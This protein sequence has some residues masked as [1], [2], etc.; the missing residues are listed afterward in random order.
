MR[1]K[2]INVVEQVIE[3][4]KIQRELGEA[5]KN[6]LNRFVRC[7]KFKTSMKL[8]LER[9][10]KAKKLVRSYIRR[11]KSRRDAVKAVAKRQKV[12]SALR[13]WIKKWRLNRT[14]QVKANNVLKGFVGRW[15]SKK[16]Q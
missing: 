7:W 11:R 10:I 13:K 16:Q 4:K 14:G 9:R 8:C 2:L 6:V 3:Q 5:S 15:R 1:R 12:K